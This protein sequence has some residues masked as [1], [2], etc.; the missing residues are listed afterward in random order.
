MRKLTLPLL[1]ALVLVF[2]LAATAQSAKEKLVGTW[3]AKVELDDE[4]LKSLLEGLD[5]DKHALKELKQQFG[6]NGKSV[7]IKAT[8]EE[9]K[10]A[11]WE[12]EFAGKDKFAFASLES[13][14]APRKKLVFNRNK[15]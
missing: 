6:E 11:V 14:E 5:L 10:E 2:P 15:E 12:I 7:K 1:A 8:D 3:K 4:M 13:N 9:G